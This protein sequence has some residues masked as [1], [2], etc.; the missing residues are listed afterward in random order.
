MAYQGH[1]GKN[2]IN[3]SIMHHFPKTPKYRLKYPSAKNY[4]K[5]LMKNINE[6]REK[7]GSCFVFSPNLNMKL[8]PNKTNSI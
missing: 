1:S 7:Q 6:L 5:C 3:S 4:W 2:T 8:N